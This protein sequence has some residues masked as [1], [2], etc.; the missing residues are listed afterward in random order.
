M[1]KRIALAPEIVAELK[2]VSRDIF[3][4]QA[5]LNSQYSGDWRQSYTLDSVEL[6]IREEMVELQREIT[7]VW[8]F[9]GGRSFN[10]DK[11]LEEFIDVLHFAATYCIIKIPRVT[12][13]AD[14]AGC[15]MPTNVLGAFDG[16]TSDRNQRVGALCNLSSVFFR[17]GNYAVNFVQLLADG[18]VFFDMT[19]SQMF[20]AYLEKNGRNHKRAERGAGVKDVDKTQ[21]RSCYEY[22]LENGFVFETINEYNERMSSCPGVGRYE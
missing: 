21:E 5:K 19:P 20:V 16:Y 17:Q 12:F 14:W 18:C 13:N 9:F 3:V 7:G 10:F 4:A 6:S 15:Y 11:A 2:E 22:M 1:L 8:K